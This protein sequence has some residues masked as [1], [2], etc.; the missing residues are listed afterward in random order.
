[1]STALSSLQ[2]GDDNSPKSLTGTPYQ[3][4]PDTPTPL[5]LSAGTSSSAKQ[6][7]AWRNRGLAGN[8][9]LSLSKNTT[10]TTYNW[11]DNS[12]GQSSI[13]ASDKGAGRN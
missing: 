2:F 3:N 4:A 1:M 10:G 5:S 6:A 9:P 13:P 8:R 7:T 11:D 12:S